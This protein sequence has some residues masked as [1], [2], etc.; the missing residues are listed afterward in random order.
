MLRILLL[1]GIRFLGIAPE[2]GLDFQHRSG[3]PKKMSWTRYSSGSS[4]SAPWPTSATNRVWAS[5]KASEMY[6]RKIN[7]PHRGSGSALLR[8]SSEEPSE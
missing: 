3:S 7:Y 8:S 6:L 2:A 4:G 5:R 1:L